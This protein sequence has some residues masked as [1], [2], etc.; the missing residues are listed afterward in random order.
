[1]SKFSNV[2]IVSPV[3]FSDESD[4]ALAFALELAGSPGNITALHVAPPLVGFEPGFAWDV[5]NDED[6]REKLFEAFSKRYSEDK[7]KG[8][9]F[10]VRF[11]DP[12]QEIADFAKQIGAGLVIMSSHGRTGLAHLLIGSVAERVVRLAP[13]P[14]LVLRA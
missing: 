6:R 5:T 7:Y 14:V 3:D 12:G 2:P 13:C 9:K 11:G 10:D 4:R 1:M 8:V